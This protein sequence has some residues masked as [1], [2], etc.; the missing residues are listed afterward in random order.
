MG[1][2]SSD[3]CHI[4]SQPELNS[5]FNKIPLLIFKQLMAEK[6]FK[7]GNQTLTGSVT[8]S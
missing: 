4:A 5:F 1:N 6:V 3:V 8:V 2:L 7:K